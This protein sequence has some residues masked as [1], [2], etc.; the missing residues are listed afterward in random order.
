MRQTIN[1]RTGKTLQIPTRMF[2]DSDLSDMQVEYVDKQILFNK[3]N[4]NESFLDVKDSVKGSMCI[5]NYPDCSNI[6]FSESKLVDVVRKQYQESGDFIVLPYFKNETEYDINLKLLL[7]KKMKSTTSKEIILEISYKN[8]RVVMDKIISSSDD[9]DYLAIFYGVHFGRQP[10]FQM[11]CEKIIQLRR[12]TEKKVFCTAVPLIFSGDRKAINSHLLPI[13]SVICDGWVKNWRRGGGGEE[14]R[15]IDFD[16]MKNKNLTDWLKNHDFGELVKY[17]NVSVCSLFQEN[18]EDERRRDIY[19]K[20]LID[21][22]LNEISSITPGNI[23]EYL[24]KRCP[25]VYQMLLLVPY[26]EK[27]LQFNFQKSEWSMYSKEELRLLKSHLRKTFS[28][29][30]LDREIKHM[31][32]L[33]SDEKKVPVEVLLTG[34]DKLRGEG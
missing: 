33:I 34:I 7:A 18:K 21:E 32:S 14:I 31:E 10:S 23:E 15:L 2:K 29:K 11:I 6:P 25:P 3:A 19:T 9:F 4:H 30:S 8:E 22:V 27:M 26:I 28:P 1:T 20:M 5:L 24:L 12:E 17:V 16:D 13:W